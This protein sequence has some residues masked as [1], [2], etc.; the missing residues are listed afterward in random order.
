M[1]RTSERMKEAQKRHYGFKP[2]R[3]QFAGDLI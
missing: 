2:P 3:S 1:T